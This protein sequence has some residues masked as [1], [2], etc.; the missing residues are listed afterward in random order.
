MPY[1][2]YAH[3]NRADLNLLHTLF[4]LLEERHVTRAASRCF[5][6][7]PAMSRALDR[8]REM[9][10]DEL[11]IRAGCKYERTARGERLLRDLESLLPRLELLL[12]GEQFDP[13]L[14]EERFR[15]TMTDHACAVLLPDLVRR[16]AGAAPKSRLEVVPWSDARFEDVEGGRLDL[17]LD[18]ASAPSNLNFEVL[19]ADVFACVVAASHPVRARRFTLHQYLKYRHVVVDVLSGQQTSVDQPLAVLGLKRQVGFVLPYFLPAALAVAQSDMILTTPS[20]LARRLEKRTHVR[21]VKAPREL[22]GF[23]YVMI[24][25]ARMTADPAHEWFRNQVRAVAKELESHA[26]VPRPISTGGRGKTRTLDPG[27]M[28]GY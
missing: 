18:V 15:V 13:G 27:I 21:V 2:P 17:V 24:W 23:K 28:S 8:L 19:F 3:I 7:Q 20:R 22:V 11:L 26:Q 14:S 10:G 4:A 6:S 1:M 25:H 16:V 5:L 9:F 12:K